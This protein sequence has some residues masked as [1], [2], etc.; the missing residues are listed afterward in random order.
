MRPGTGPTFQ[1]MT[2]SVGCLYVTNLLWN[3]TCTRASRIQTDR[4]GLKIAA[5]SD[6][7]LFVSNLLH[8]CRPMDVSWNYGYS[9]YP[10]GRALYSRPITLSPRTSSD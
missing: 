9:L 5:D 3:C 1:R 8:S 2:W 6:I 4:D 10:P 7:G